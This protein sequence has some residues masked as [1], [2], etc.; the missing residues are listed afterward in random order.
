MDNRRLFLF[1][2]LVLVAFL[3]YQAWMHDYGPKP[4]PSGAPTAA[5]TTAPSAATAALPQIPAA[6]GSAPAA[7]TN[8]ANT[9]AAPAR[10]VRA[11]AAGEPIDVRT[12]LLAVT[13]NT[14]GGELQ[15]AELLA[16]PQELHQPA[17]VKALNPDSA[18]LLVAH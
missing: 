3:I 6:P 13:I 7:A 1:A 12:D 8:V 17:R 16:Y 15:Q 11:Q 18:S 14:A 10:E 5:T 9:V 4:P 2:A